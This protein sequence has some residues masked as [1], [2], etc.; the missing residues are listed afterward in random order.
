MRGHPFALNVSPLAASYRVPIII[1]CTLV[2]DGPGEGGGEGV[3]FRVHNVCFDLVSRRRNKTNRLIWFNLFSIPENKAARKART[4]LDE[5]HKIIRV[6]NVCEPFSDLTTR[7]TLAPS[8]R[9][10]YNLFEILHGQRKIYRVQSA[11]T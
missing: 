6:H 5:F 8:Q 7:N 3:F 1:D 2:R 9:I 10:K 11:E 4:Q